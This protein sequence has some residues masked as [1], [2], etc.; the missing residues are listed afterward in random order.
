[1][2]GRETGHPYFPFLTHM[3]RHHKTITELLYGEQGSY[4][5]KT[6]RKFFSSMATGKATA[7][8]YATAQKMM[9]SQLPALHDIVGQHSKPAFC[10]IPAVL[11]EPSTMGDKVKK[12]LLLRYNVLNEADTLLSSSLYNA[13]SAYEVSDEDIWALKEEVLL[14][15]KMLQTAITGCLQIETNRNLAWV[16]G[17]VST[18]TILE[19]MRAKLK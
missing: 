17:S 1:M 4:L 6:W 7:E 18:K 9:G 16:Q 13:F 2:G 8:Q 3:A 14:A 10:L 11:F 12:R 15:H 5:T 19:K